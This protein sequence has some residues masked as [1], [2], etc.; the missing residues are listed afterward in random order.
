MIGIIQDDDC[1]TM[2]D[3]QRQR[4]LVDQRNYQNCNTLC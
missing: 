2:S 4:G 1:G 3:V